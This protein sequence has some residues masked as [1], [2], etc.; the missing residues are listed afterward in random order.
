MAT[1][2]PRKTTNLGFDKPRRN[3]Q[4]QTLIHFID[5]HDQ[6][7]SPLLKRWVGDRNVAGKSS[8]FETIVCGDILVTYQSGSDYHQH[9]DFYRVSI[10]CQYQFSLS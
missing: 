3:F 5:V 1:N 8:H 10:L 6:L 7:F 9:F 4:L 2:T